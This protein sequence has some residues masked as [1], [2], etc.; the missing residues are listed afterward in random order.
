[1]SDVELKITLPDAPVEQQIRMLRSF[2]TI[3]RIAAKLTGKS[4]KNE[5]AQ[6]NAAIKRLQKNLRKEAV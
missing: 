3:V 1:M 2:K 6:L 5:I 4:P